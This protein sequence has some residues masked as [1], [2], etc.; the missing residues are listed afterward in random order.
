MHL[1]TGFMQAA[2]NSISIITATYNAASTVANYLRG[3]ASQTHPAE[4]ISHQRRF[5]RY[6]VS[7]RTI[8][9]SFDNLHEILP[10]LIINTIN[11]EVL[12]FIPSVVV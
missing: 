7:L 12:N 5:Q 10:H 1:L 8:G 3:V 9:K 4:R 11:P 6:H 2:M